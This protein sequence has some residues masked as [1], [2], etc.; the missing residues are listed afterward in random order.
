MI[1]RQIQI[2]SLLALLIA[3]GIAAQAQPSGC[4]ARLDAPLVTIALPG[5]PFGVLSSRDGCWV[6][7]SMGSGIAVLKRQGGHIELMRVVRVTLSPAGMVLTHDGKLLIAACNNATVVLDVA[8]MTAGAPNPVVGTFSGRE[9]KF[10]GSVYTNI[11]ADDK[12]LFVSEE[13]AQS[14]TVID[15][16]R[17][18]Q[19]GYKSDAIIGTIPVGRAPIALTLSSDGKWLYTTSELAAVDWGW[20]TACKPEVSGRTDLV[21]PEG[22]VVIVDVARARTD[23]SNAAVARIPAGCS[24]V[25]MAISPDGGR[26]YVTA[27]NSNAVEAFDTAKLLT[28]QAH[29]RVGMAAVGDAPVPVAV[30]DGGKKV[31]AGNSNRFAEGNTPQTLSVLDAAKIE[32]P[33]ADAGLGTI[34]S[35]AFPRE[36]SVSADGQTL[37]LSNAGSSSIQV[38]DIDRLPVRP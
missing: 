37:F 17:A 32:Q 18:R 31:V 16:E 36:M 7:A 3:A 33:G 6:F 34:T 28:D 12:M 30:I 21:N 4:N 5:N 9:A 10:L 1:F 11:T 19:N 38:M 2:R 20:P 13:A 24:P 35:G 23:P 27:R 14:I 29:A 8:Q 22:A 25:R 15:L 26:I